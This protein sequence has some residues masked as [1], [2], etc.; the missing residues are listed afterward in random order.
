MKKYLFGVCLVAAF[1]AV[2]EITETDTDMTAQGDWEVTVEN[3]MWG[4]TRIHTQKRVMAKGYCYADETVIKEDECLFL[5]DE[6]PLNT[7]IRFKVTP[8]NSF[9]QGGVPIFSSNVTLPIK[10]K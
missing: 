1:G 5:Q 2:G 10:G 3:L 8:L 9:S 4:F 7:P 6:L